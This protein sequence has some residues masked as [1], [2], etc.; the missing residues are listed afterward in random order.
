MAPVARRVS[1]RWRLLAGLGGLVALTG[2]VWPRFLSAPA[3]DGT[4]GP[5]V[6]TAPSL[7]RIAETDASGG[8]AAVELWA[9]RGETESFQIAVRAPSGGLTSVV[10]TVGDLRGPDDAVITAADLALYREHY[11]TVAHGSR[12]LEG[13]NRPLG[14]GRY[15][16]ALIPFVD[17]DTGQ[18]PLPSALPATP[19]SVTAGRTQPVW[20]DV[21]VPAT[22]A[23]GQYRGRFSV[24]SDQGSASGLVTVQVWA[25][26]LPA[27]PALKSV[28]SFGHGDSGTRAQ[29][30]ELLRH[31]LSPISVAR[32]DESTFVDAHGLGA[33]ALGFWSDA[34]HANCDRMTAPPTVE[35]IAARA[36]ARDPRLF[37]YNYTA[38]EIGECAA[39]FPG[40]KDWARRLHEA[41]VK[42]L[43]TMPPTPALF[44]DGAGH[45]RSAVDIWVVLPKQYDAQAAA[46]RA[47]LAK[48]DEV[49]S[50]NALVQDD[51]SPKWLIDYA[52]INFR[53]QPGFL[54][55]SLRLTG[56]LYW[57]VDR[58]DGDPWQE[59]DNVG[60]FARGASYP[61]EG[62]LVYPGAPAGLVGA[63]PSM[64][65]KWIRDGVDDYDY[66]ALLRSRG[67]GEWADGVVQR[68]APDWRAWRRETAAI[69]T[70][71]RE[72]GEELHRLAADT[73]AR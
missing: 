47:A 6:W 40:L 10:V 64:R 11:V 61:G 30:L 73:A 35:A 15:A 48:G 26:T 56:L 12:D 3:V 49:W 4:S 33:G 69:E 14:A 1:R 66:V 60:A 5:I 32:E 63:A 55:Q 13:A 19:F 71:R 27:R 34:N 52:P 29:N 59:A 46:V 41:G 23:P 31:R 58:W 21:R 38:D 36:S 42:N 18:P 24:T 44:D 50:Y 70:A 7:D 51:Y 25:F 9:A 65:L 57:R 53:L 68:V 72:L 2:L 37:L 20:V 17:P 28:F 54:S 16:D 67:R 43:V 22:A 45:G 39:L 8:P 62:M